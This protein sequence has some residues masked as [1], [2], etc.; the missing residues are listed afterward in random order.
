MIHV[1]RRNNR[2]FLLM[3]TAYEFYFVVILSFGFKLL[4]L[5]LGYNN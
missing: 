2:F 4:P 3:G 1:K 5:S